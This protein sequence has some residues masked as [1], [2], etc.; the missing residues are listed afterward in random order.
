M[1]CDVRTNECSG[2]RKEGRKE[3]GRR[4]QG[5]GHAKADDALRCVNEGTSAGTNECLRGKQTREVRAVKNSRQ[6]SF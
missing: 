5:D 3:D 1:D 4:L 2:G 6:R